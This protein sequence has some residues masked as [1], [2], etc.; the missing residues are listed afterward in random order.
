[1]SVFNLANTIS[2]TRI[3]LIVPCIYFFEVGEPYIGLFIL[4]LM[5]ITDYADGIAARKLDSVSDFG[6]AFDPICD[7]IAIISLIAYLVISKD[8]PV[9]LVI[10]LI[11]RDLILAYL[12]ILSRKRSGVMPYSNISGKIF[13]N[14]VALLIIS[15]FMD[16]ELIKQLSLYLSIPLFLYSTV[17]YLRDYYKI[18]SI[19]YPTK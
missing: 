16:W 7:K 6:K 5:V 15:W 8:F 9:S 3:I 18:L 19:S 17:I 1:M 10:I 4:I 12:G 2:F 14:T 11:V 13:V